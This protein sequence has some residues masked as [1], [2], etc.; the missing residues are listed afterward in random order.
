MH[1][2][3]RFRLFGGFNPRN[4]P[5]NTGLLDHLYKSSETGQLLGM[6]VD[7][8]SSSDYSVHR[9][10]RAAYVLILALTRPDEQPLTVRQR[11]S[12]D[13]NH[14]DTG[15]IMFYTLDRCHTET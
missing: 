2:G 9:C 3:A 1:S 12:S 14:N 15:L 11:Q 8:S 7:Q 5:L 4:P 10:S 6:P 13:T